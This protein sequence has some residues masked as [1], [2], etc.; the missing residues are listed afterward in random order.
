VGHPPPRVIVSVTAAACIIVSRPA[1]WQPARAF[2][3]SPD[4]FDVLGELKAGALNVR[5]LARA[6]AGCS[7]LPPAAA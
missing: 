6:L 7:P 1:A 4:C 5:A 2:F 3:R